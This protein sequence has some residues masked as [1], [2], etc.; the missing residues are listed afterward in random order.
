M[1]KTK[2]YIL[3]FTW[4]I[5]MTLIGCIVA[6]ILRAMGYKPKRYGYCWHFEVGER[7]GGVNLGIVFITS[8]N[9]STHTKNH[10]HGH[11]LQN[12]YWGFLFPFVIAI[13][14]LV[15]YWYF[16]LTPNKKHPP[17][18]SIWF[19]GQA[20]EWGDKLMKII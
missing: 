5:P 14:S 18:D 6:L 3:S 4:G 9:P 7:W 15:R 10:E 1:N 2:F 17:Y 12:C 13:P 19:E 20:T 16:I 11:A 8:K